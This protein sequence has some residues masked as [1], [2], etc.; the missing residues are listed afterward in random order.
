M[1][2]VSEVFQR[3]WIECHANDGIQLNKPVS[4]PV[5]LSPLILLLSMNMQRL[6]KLLL[7]P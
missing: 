4:A 3:N 2:N 6:C 5:Q 7:E 1:Q